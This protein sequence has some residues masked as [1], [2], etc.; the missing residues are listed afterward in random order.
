M[1]VSHRKQ[2]LAWRCILGGSFAEAELSSQTRQDV[3]V[4][5][6]VVLA[7]AADMPASVA[8]AGL[9]SPL[10]LPQ[11]FMLQP[12]VAAQQEE[13]LCTRNPKHQLVTY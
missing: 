3:M 10:P 9:P 6:P 2:A 8:I 4:V 5:K 12:T 1:N 7:D 11:D 13:R